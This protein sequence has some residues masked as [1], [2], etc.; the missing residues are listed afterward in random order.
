MWCVFHA[1]RGDERQG[2]V[3]QRQ[4]QHFMG[5]NRYRPHST[6]QH[7]TAEQRTRRRQDRRSKIG[8]Q[9]ELHGTNAD[10]LEACSVLVLFLSCPSL[11]VPIVG[12][13]GIAGIMR[14][15]RV[16]M[17]VS[18][19]SGDE[20]LKNS[21][22]VVPPTR[23]SF[24]TAVKTASSSASRNDGS[25]GSNLQASIPTLSEAQV[26]DFWSR[27]SLSNAKRSS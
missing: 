5:H 25:D 8:Q 12:I 27:R 2:R 23:Q 20:R 3:S 1:E 14:L 24:K 18:C 9:H 17:H 15:T 10:Y 7:S 11:H 26:I 21:P 22:D 16:H 6:V 4:L 19:P 13:A